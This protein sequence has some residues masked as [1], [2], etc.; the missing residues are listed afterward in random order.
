MIVLPDADVYGAL[1]WT[2][3]D[4]MDT[5][6]AI[7]I[8]LIE[9]KFISEDNCAPLLSIPALRVTEKCHT[10]SMMTLCQ[11][12]MDDSFPLQQVYITLKVAHRP[13]AYNAVRRDP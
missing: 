7:K 6:A 12:Q 9:M 10:S 4:T 3:P 11:R 5:S 2:S 13:V 8:Q 1:A